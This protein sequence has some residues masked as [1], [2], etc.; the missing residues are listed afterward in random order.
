VTIPDHTQIP[1][2]Q[3]FDKVWRMSN[4]GSCSW[5]QGTV[6]V[7]VSGFKMSAP[8]TVPVPS[9]APGGT[10]DIG[11][12]MYAP[13]SP[14][15]Y[16][17]VWQLKDPAGQIFGSRVTVV[18]NVPDPNPAPAPTPQPPP[19]PQPSQPTINFW[20][21]VGKVCENQCTNIHWDVRNV[22]AVYVQY[23]GHSDGVAGQGSRWVC[24]SSDGKTY[25]LVVDLVDGSQQTRQLKID[26]D[27]SC[28]GPSPTPTPKPHDDRYVSVSVNPKEIDKGQCTT[29][30]WDVKNYHKIRFLDTGRPAKGSTQWCPTKSTTETFTVYYNES[31][32]DRKDVSVS[33]K[34]K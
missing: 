25:T 19:P 6:L 15:T 2:A 32:S 5:E 34:V 31:G 28:G 10:A 26:I 1:A 16:T 7:F 12:T 24:P 4:T 11:V 13:S 17:G 27:H 22:R 29:V 9:T 23:G 8:D 3:Q 21:D 18:I 14:G 20:S 30:S 33:V